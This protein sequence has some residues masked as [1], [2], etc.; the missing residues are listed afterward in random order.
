M[1]WILLLVLA[2][3]PGP[4]QATYA[5]TTG[6]AISATTW[7]THDLCLAAKAAIIGDT[8]RSAILVISARCQLQTAEAG[9]K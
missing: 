5:Q 2:S 3:T 4:S 1:S 6:I 7:Q 8:M 9:L